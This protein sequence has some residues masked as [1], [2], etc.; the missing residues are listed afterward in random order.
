MP[1]LLV[2]DADRCGLIMEFE[3]NKKKAKVL[4]KKEAKK[5]V[6]RAFKT[7]VIDGKTYYNAIF[8]EE[9]IPGIGHRVN[10]ND[11]IKLAK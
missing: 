2:P 3:N 7:I 1:E 11:E 8:L 6:G 9:D 10:L 4:S 5:Y